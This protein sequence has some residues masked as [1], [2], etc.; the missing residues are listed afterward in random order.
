MIEEVIWCNLVPTITK[1]IKTQRTILRRIAALLNTRD[2]KF[3]S[4]DVR[5]ALPV[6]FQTTFRHHMS[7]RITHLSLSINPT[8]KFADIGNTEQTSICVPMLVRHAFH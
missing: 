2:Q 8:V 7:H 6:Y 1:S 5:S 3:Q 4:K